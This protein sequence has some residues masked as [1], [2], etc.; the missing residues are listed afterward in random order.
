MLHVLSGSTRTFIA[1]Q[2][3]SGLAPGDRGHAIALARVALRRALQ[4][5]S[6]DQ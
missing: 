1:V 3:S 4:P 2:G 6:P 5:A